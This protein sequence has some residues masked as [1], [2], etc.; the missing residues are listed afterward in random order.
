MRF[1]SPLYAGMKLSNGKAVKIDPKELKLVGD[2]QR[3]TPNL[4]SIKKLA[5]LSHVGVHGLDNLDV[6]SA[7]VE[8]G[9]LNLKLDVPVLDKTISNKVVTEQLK[10]ITVCGS[11]RENHG[12][13]GWTPLK[14]TW[15]HVNDFFKEM[16]EFSDPIQGSVGD[17]WLI[18][19][20]SAVAWALPYDVVHCNRATR[21][22]NEK[23]HMNKLNFY[24]K[25]YGRDGKNKS[26][27][28]TEKCLV[29]NGTSILVYARSQD[30][31][32]IWPAVYEKAFA[33]WTGPEDSDMPDIASLA[34]G[35]PALAMAQLTDRKPQ[36]F[37]TASRDASTLWGI[38]RSHS[39]SYKTFDPMTAW[40]HASGSQYTYGSGIAANHAYSILGWAFRNNK[41]YIVMRNPWGFFEPT[42]GNTYNGVVQ[43]FDETFWRPINM[44]PKD[45]VFA[46]EAESFKDYFACIGLAI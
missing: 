6:E 22:G 33:R 25:G 17:C 16:T 24:K 38:V 14:T 35:D 5:D 40:T 37:D 15:E 7:R 36:Y 26:V 20:L 30:M 12:K 46:I 27:E 41:M 45:G 21:S 1:N 43:M 3:A 29:A 44:I 2:D 34:G 28:V 42:G 10:S 4:G 32:E 11:D 9:K 18:A 8:N 39:R 31:G 19:A 13:S 23:E